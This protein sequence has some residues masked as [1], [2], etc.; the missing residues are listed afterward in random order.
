MCDLAGIAVPEGVDGRSLVPVLTG[1]REEI[2]DAV[3]AHFRD[4]Q[5]MVRTPEWKYVV[6]PQAG[7][8][9]LFRVAGDPDELRNLAG[10][11]AYAEVLEDMRGRL[12]T[13]RQER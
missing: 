5:R 12:T 10:D 11:A 9:Q 6:Y 2:Y 7:R 13:W 4:S 8:E 1:E 3:Y